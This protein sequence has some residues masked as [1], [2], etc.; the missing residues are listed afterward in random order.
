MESSSVQARLASA[1]GGALDALAGVNGKIAYLAGAGGCGMRGAVQ[2][3][4]SE[5][6]EVWGEDSA[7]WD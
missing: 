3:L 4:M 5:G 1:G 6:W 2:W 7:G